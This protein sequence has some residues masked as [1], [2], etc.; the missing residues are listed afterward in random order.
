MRVIRAVAFDACSRR[1]NPFPLLGPVTGVALQ[2]SVRAG[3]RIG[4]LRGVIESPK[5]PSVGRMARC[6]C[7]TQ[8]AIVVRIFVAALA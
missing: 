4:S 8:S 6:A 2:R 7:G 5:R 1:R 3:E